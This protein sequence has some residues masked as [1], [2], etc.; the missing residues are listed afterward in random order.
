MHLSL[1][2]FSSLPQPRP[3]QEHAAITYPLCNDTHNGHFPTA[4]WR[5]ETVQTSGN[6]DIAWGSESGGGEEH[7]ATGDHECVYE[8]V[9]GARNSNRSVD[10]VSVCVCVSLC[11]CVCVCECESVRVCE[12]VYENALVNSMFMAEADVDHAATAT[13]KG[14][15]RDVGNGERQVS[16]SDTQ[17]LISGGS[18]DG[19]DSI[20]HSAIPAYISPDP[21]T[22]P[23]T[24][25]QQSST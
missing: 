17:R 9:H 11:V 6:V 20:R 18:A 5:Q 24:T 1:P 22:K 16:G 25:S 19:L 13:N 15:H 21:C 14:R 8:V 3:P 4:E 7:G 10:R 23:P 2:P 12:C